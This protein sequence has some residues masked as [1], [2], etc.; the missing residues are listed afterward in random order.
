MAGGAGG[1]R[2]G[3]AYWELSIDSSRINS[4]LAQVESKLRRASLNIAKAGLGLTTFGAGILA[5][6]RPAIIAASSLEEAVNRFNVV[7]GDNAASVSAWA[8][9]F[10]RDT[11]R[12]KNVFIDFLS[13]AASFFSATG[14]DTA[15]TAALSKVVTRLSVDL[16][17]FRDIPIEEAFQ[18]I[19]AGL[20]G[21]SEALDRFGVD[22]REASL[23]AELFRRGIDFSDAS[24]AQKR[25]GRLSLILKQQASATNDATRTSR[26]FANQMR[27]LKDAVRDANIAM[28][29]AAI[30]AIRPYIGVL[31]GVAF[32][33]RAWAEE[34]P[35]AIVSVLQLGVAAT[36]AGGALLGLSFIL[37]TTAAAF[38]V[39]Q[40]IITAG[41][42]AFNA[43]KTVAALIN[44]IFKALSSG[45]VAAATSANIA[46]ATAVI[47]SAGATLQLTGAASSAVLAISAYGTALLGAATAGASYGAMVVAN[48]PTFYAWSASAAAAATG[49]IAFSGALVSMAGTAAAAAVGLLPFLQAMI[50]LPPLMLEVSGTGFILIGGL[51]SIATSAGAAAAAIVGVTGA[52]VAMTASLIPLP[53]L[54]LTT[55]GNGFILISSFTGLAVSA[56]AAATAMAALGAAMGPVIIELISITTFGAAASTALVTMA[57]GALAVSGSNAL[58]TTSMLALGAAAQFVTVELIGVT[59]AEVAAAATTS[60]LVFPFAALASAIGGVAIALAAFLVPLYVVGRGVLFVQGAIAHLGRSMQVLG[61]ATEGV[62]GALTAGDLRGAWEVT[63]AAINVE[64]L[65]MLRS[66][67]RALTGF[68]SDML[69]V[70]AQVIP[71]I[72]IAL[73]DTLKTA[74]QGGLNWKQALAGIGTALMS[75]IDFALSGSELD[76]AIAQA[77]RELA[78]KAG[79][80]KLEGLKAS[81]AIQGAR[82][83]LAQQQAEIDRVLGNLNTP[84]SGKDADAARKKDQAAIE[85]QQ[86][87]GAIDDLL[88]TIR[89]SLDR[90]TQEAEEVEQVRELSQN[91]NLSEDQRKQFD[92]LLT[93]LDAR[94]RES[95]FEQN[96]L[97]KQ[98]DLL[99]DKDLS[100]DEARRMGELLPEFFRAGFLDQAKGI[101]EKQEP[102]RFDTLRTTVADIASLAPQMFVGEEVD[103]A[104][105]SELKGLRKEAVKQTQQLAPLAALPMLGRAR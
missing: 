39:L 9:S 64:W 13:T 23:R 99:K 83:Q 27:Q 15:D 58:A 4:G 100:L 41:V 104:Q 14:F 75:T 74:L 87:Q 66:M 26:S 88:V 6:F 51:A 46:Y 69:G 47:A 12:S 8:D 2:A 16:A 77:E 48:I 65:R 79:R 31:R 42:V 19:T 90:A 29:R 72:G 37:R 62:M 82:D 80:A 11:R 18:R 40:G 101:L 3:G 5:G 44:T 25:L 28:G 49:T 59:T 55:S 7:F 85:R 21:S 32:G 68:V 89:K 71:G 10:A 81:Q 35:K 103:R 97:F 91:P 43:F 57:G 50:A 54:L 92:D 78:E 70:F 33:V 30:E 36:A 53:P 84:V 63:T 102:P 61:I 95:R 22:I 76:A 17:S 1:I 105:L 98:L 94:T 34:N 96:R 52:L 73:G 67:H 93:Q 60:A 20:S 38:A 56:G 24:E 86:R 45:A